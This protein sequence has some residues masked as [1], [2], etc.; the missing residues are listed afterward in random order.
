M[1]AP[2]TGCGMDHTERLYWFFA[3][4]VVQ[5]IICNVKLKILKN[6][7]FNGDTPT[8]IHRLVLYCVQ[9]QQELHLDW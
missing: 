2:G 4:A 1:A 6:T 5:D 9:A 7:H 8:P 3:Y